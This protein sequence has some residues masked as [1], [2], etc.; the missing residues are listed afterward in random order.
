MLPLGIRTK[1]AFFDAIK[2]TLPLDPPIVGSQSWDA[3]SDS[4][5][6]GLDNSTAQQLAIIWPG[7][8][9]MARTEC[10]EFEQATSV[11]SDI[12][13]LLADPEAT[14]GQTKALVVLL[15]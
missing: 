1:T 10:E 7:S 2:A 4:I 3:L 15:A 9:E 14:V 6:N 12:S 5:W 11:L 8:D 13:D